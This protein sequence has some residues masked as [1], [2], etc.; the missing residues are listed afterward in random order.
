MREGSERRD[1]VRFGFNVEDVLEPSTPSSAVA[2]S[3]VLVF[4][5]DVVLSV[6]TVIVL[7]LLAVFSVLDVV[8]V[9]AAS[10]IPSSGDPLT[11]VSSFPD[12]LLVV[13]IFADFLLSPIE[14]SRWFSYI[15]FSKDQK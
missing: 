4:S 8:V 5:V 7:G 9:V 10:A 11:W 3:V 13:G 15:R 6:L 1:F 2:L 12:W 14:C